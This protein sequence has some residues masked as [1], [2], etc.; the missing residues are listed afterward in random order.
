MQKYGFF[1]SQV[2]AILNVPYMAAREVGG[3]NCF[4]HFHDEVTPEVTQTY[5]DSDMEKQQKK[6]KEGKEE[7]YF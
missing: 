3:L 4:H 6:G 5:S 1:F 7:D 2:A